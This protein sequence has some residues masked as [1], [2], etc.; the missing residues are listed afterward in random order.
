MKEVSKREIILYNELLMAANNI[1]TVLVIFGATGDL[2]TKKIT[3]ALFNLHQK[4]KLPK[5][6]RVIGVARRNLSREQFHGHIIKIL[7]ESDEWTGNKKEAER[8]LNFFYYHPG[9]FEERADYDSLAV[10]LGRVDGEWK[11]CSN[12]L[13]YLAVPPQFYEMIFK[14][15]AG[16]GLTIPCGPEE[17]WTR[18]LVEKPFGKDEKTAEKLDLLLV[19]LFKEE[20]IYRIDHYLAKEMLQNILSFRFS[21]NILEESWNGKFIEKIE[22]RLLEKIGAE[23]RGIF[24]DEVG[25]LRDVGQNHLLQMLAFVAMEHPKSYN[26]DVIRRARAEILK[27]LVPPR[28]NDIVANTFRAQYEG[29]RDIEGVKKTSQTETYF[30]IRGELDIPRWRGVPIYFE[31]GKRLKKPVKEIIITFRHVEP[32]LCPPGAGHYKNQ[33]KFSLE[34]VEGIHITFLSKKPGLQ[35]EVEPRTL[36][37]T[38]RHKNQKTQ[39]VEEYEKLLLDCIEGNQM[40]FLSTDEVKA[41]WHFIDPVIKWWKEGAVPLAT[42]KPDTDEIL[43]EQP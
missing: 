28:K 17:G 31:S 15:L 7:K 19:R 14:H 26:A 20:Q 9:R 33:I 23:G 35:M 24:Y 10:E 36:E 43:A 3:P 32:C 21:N 22:I 2:M 4:G 39:Y 25:A 34:P 5:M 27:H 16:S 41:M 11:V 1:P 18:V 8:F 6:F 29:Y 12:K 38:Y 30:R 37:F 13:F 42:Y 40:L